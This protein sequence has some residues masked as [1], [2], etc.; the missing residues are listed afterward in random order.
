MKK[1]TQKM[2]IIKKNAIHSLRKLNNSVVGNIV[3]LLSGSVFTALLGLLTA[4]ILTRIYNP[5]S[6]GFLAIFMSVVT[7]IAP[8]A[9]L[10]YELSITLYKND[11]IAQYGLILAII[12]AILVSVVVGILLYIFRDFLVMEE[13]SGSLEI[14]IIFIPISI[15]CLSIITTINYWFTRIKKFHYQSLTHISQN[16]IRV[17]LQIAF[18]FVHYFQVVGLL[19]GQIIAHLSGMLIITC[20]YLQNINSNNT[21]KKIKKGSLVKF[22]HS[23]KNL[24]KHAFT[25]NFLNGLAGNVFPLVL[26]YYFSPAAAGLLFLAQQVLAAPVG[27][28]TSA[29][30]RVYYG[31]L[32]ERRDD[33]I[34]SQAS[35]YKIHTGMSVL[36][37]IPIFLVISFSEYSILFF[38]DEWDD[39]YKIIP[40]F[41]IFVFAKNLSNSVSYF[42]V[43]SK[44][45][46]ESIWN[47]V[48]LSVRIG[49]ILVASITTDDPAICIS[50]YCLLS[51]TVYFGINTYWGYLTNQIIPFWKNILFMFV[52]MFAAS[53]YFLNQVEQIELKVLY[54]IIILAL[55]LSLSIKKLNR[56]N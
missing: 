19:A 11:R 5:T 51:T 44:F 50:F 36:L 28:I 7:S 42:T 34:S 41:C 35:L 17:T 2:K 52:P 43:F 18:G 31:R 21:R 53:F 15:L 46:A 30:W 54:T 4:P 9:T 33:P 14:Y 13:A 48:N 22:A 49:A 26:A 37:T 56:I 16:I 6:Y 10:R 47:V 29:L 40:A 55:F 1:S 25:T 45:F 32:S 20:L 12:S 27:M 8:V 38:G 23:N 3:V 39:F 24:P